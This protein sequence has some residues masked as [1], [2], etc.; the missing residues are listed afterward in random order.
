M[1]LRSPHSTLMSFAP[2]QYIRRRQTRRVKRG[3]IGWPCLLVPTCHPPSFYQGSIHSAGP[4]LRG[5][6]LDCGTLVEASLTAADGK[7][8]NYP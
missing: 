6:R 4:T 7:G 2:V 5:R 1:A 8:V 3:L